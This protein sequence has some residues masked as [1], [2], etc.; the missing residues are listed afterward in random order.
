MGKQVFSKDFCGRTLTF[1]IGEIAKQA[2]GA[3]LVRYDDTVV[4]STAVGSDVA[5]DIDFFPLTVSFEEK[6]YAVG[7]IP[8]SF[9]RRR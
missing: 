5:K 4:L 6:L 3:V 8:G 1:E 2:D 9:L 7:K